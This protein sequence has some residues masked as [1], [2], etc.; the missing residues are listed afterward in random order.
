MFQFLEMITFSFILNLPLSRWRSYYV[1]DQ[2]ESDIELSIRKT[3]LKQYK[4]ECI[5]LIE[6]T[7]RDL[8]NIKTELNQYISS[9]QVHYPVYKSDCRKKHFYNQDHNKLR[10]DLNI[11]IRIKCHGPR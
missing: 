8:R 6:E 5:K 4:C 9:L 11:S 7:A 2:S 10:K 3:N 1:K